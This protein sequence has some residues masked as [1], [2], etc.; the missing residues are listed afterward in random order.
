MTRYRRLRRAAL[1]PEGTTVRALLLVAILL[2]AACGDDGDGGEGAG[3]PATS[4]APAATELTLAGVGVDLDAPM[5]AHPVGT[6][7]LVAERAGLVRELVPDGDG[8][9][10]DGGTVVDVRDEVG[11]TDSEKGLLGVTTDAAGERL[12]LNHTRAEDGATVILELP[13]RGGPGEL[14]AGEARR[15][16]VIDQPFANHNG[17]DLAW[18][19]DGMLWVGTGDG[20]AADDPDGRAQRLDTLL[21]KLLRID[22]SLRG[23]GADLAP[24]D[25]PYAGDGAV[26]ADPLIWARGLRNPWRIS[27]DAGTGDLWVADVGQNRVEEVSVL[28][29]GEGLGRGS[30]LGWD[31]LEGD[32]AFAGAGPTDGWPDDGAPV[33]DPVHTYGHGPGCSV[34]GGFV[35]RGDALP[36]LDGHYLF[37]D[38]C[39]G[40]L[41]AL[42]PDGEQVD[43]GVTGDAV[44][45]INPG[46]DGEPL[47]LDAA[48]VRRITP[49]G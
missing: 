41:R 39:D 15:L 24:A 2:V 46:P 42:G 17:G 43:V 26:E 9:Y 38:Y 31:R 3:V 10:R 27:F 48:G 8:G 40:A 35:Y 33:I 7:L 22:P 37:S 18:G 25:N 20:G 12:Y 11:S 6:S 14:E 47:V 34:T 4:G 44:V 49:A 28:R 30:D 29:A 36:E 23:D 13:L 32:Q 21:G 19:P 16:L 1:L 45:S 5:D